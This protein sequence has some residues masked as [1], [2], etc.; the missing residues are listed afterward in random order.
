M[1]IVD[2]SRLLRR[3][4]HPLIH[5]LPHG[6]EKTS[7]T[8]TKSLDR[9]QRRTVHKNSSIVLGA[10]GGDFWVRFLEADLPA[11]EAAYDHN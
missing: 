6:Y 5:L 11:A 2:V 3:Q 10:L 7:T 9:P 1:D 8:S 4:K